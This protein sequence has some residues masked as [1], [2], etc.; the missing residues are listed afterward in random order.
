M[1]FKY[2]DDGQSI[3]VEINDDPQ[4]ITIKKSV[5][6]IR[7]QILKD[8]TTKY[9]NFEEGS[10]LTTIVESCFEGSSLVKIDFSNCS[11]LT[12]LSKWCF[13][14]CYNLEEC[15]LPMNSRFTTLTIGSL[16][17]CTALK[18]FSFPSTCKHFD[19]CNGYDTAVFHGCGRMKSVYF[20]IDSCLENIGSFGFIGCTSLTEIRLPM[21]IKKIE[22]CAFQSCTNL[23]NLFISSNAVI[24]TSIFNMATSNVKCVFYI[25]KETKAMLISSGL[26]QSQMRR[27]KVHFIT[28][29]RNQHRVSFE[30]VLFIMLD[31]RY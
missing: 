14:K 9:I 29:H 20:P 22:Q 13:F 7:N 11:E 10:A 25:H 24:G 6:E 18:S 31:K 17:Y 21:T 26:S 3:L 5:V 15:I 2:D 8:K 1:S 30:I 16:S 4:S 12:C 19:S 28:C 23:A 27:L